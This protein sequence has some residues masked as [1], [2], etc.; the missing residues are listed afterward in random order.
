MSM[1]AADGLPMY[2]HVLLGRNFGSAIRNE[3]S[4]QPSFWGLVTAASFLVVD[5]SEEKLLAE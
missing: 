5:G 2:G 1:R 4:C 3:R